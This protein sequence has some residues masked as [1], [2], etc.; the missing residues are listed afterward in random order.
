M[1]KIINWKK[2][3]KKKKNKLIKGI[4]EIFTHE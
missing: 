3:A 2:A 4:G 1:V